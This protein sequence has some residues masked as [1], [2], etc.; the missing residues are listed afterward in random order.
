MKYQKAIKIL[1][2]EKECVKRA[3][4]NNC[5]RNCLNCELVQNTETILRAFDTAVSAL[6][7][8]IPQTPSESHGAYTVICP[9]CY[10]QVISGKFCIECGQAL[11]E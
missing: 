10:E 7:K 9:S 8:Q 6:E 2:N 3:D 5:N 4:K 11:K 1:E